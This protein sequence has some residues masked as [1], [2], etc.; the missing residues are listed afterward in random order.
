MPVPMTRELTKL[1]N[2]AE[3]LLVTY[4]EHKDSEHCDIRRKVHLDIDRFLMEHREEAMLLIVDGLNE[5]IKRMTDKAKHL[6]NHKP[7]MP[8]LTRLKSALRRQQ[9]SPS[10]G[11]VHDIKEPV[12]YELK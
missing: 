4:T 5:E 10:S 9:P 2:E 1:R 6:H 11:P 3:R 7:K 8:L 12:E